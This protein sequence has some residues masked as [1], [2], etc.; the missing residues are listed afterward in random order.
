MKG[1]LFALV[2]AALLV[3]T[4]TPAAANHQSHDS[5]LGP[6]CLGHGFCILL[7]NQGSSVHAVDSFSGQLQLRATCLASG[8]VTQG[9]GM[10][11]NPCGRRDP[12]IHVE[13]G[14]GAIT[15]CVWVGR[16]TSS[17]PC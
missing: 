16:A 4:A 14:L 12:D 3:A 11:P 6:A 8:N 10:V 2:A 5:F 7:N 17:A 15:G 13:L 9:T 1:P